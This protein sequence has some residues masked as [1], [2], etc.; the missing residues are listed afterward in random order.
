VSLFLSGRLVYNSAYQK[1]LCKRH[2]SITTRRIPFVDD[3]RSPSSILPCNMSNMS[4]LP[5]PPIDINPP[6]R[7]SSSSPRNQTSNLTAGLQRARASSPDSQ[8]GF[9]IR[10][11]DNL[12]PAFA[13]QESSNYFPSSLSGARPIGAGSKSRRES[14]PGSYMGGMS[15]GGLSVGSF[16]Q[17]E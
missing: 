16:I 7:F 2:S 17:D 4:S 10:P 9:S 6:S 1:P 12:K 3:F 13:R 15:W 5:T 8:T 14:M 11:N